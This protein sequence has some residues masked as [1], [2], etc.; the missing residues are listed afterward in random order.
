MKTDGDELLVNTIGSYTGTTAVGFRGE[1]A[2]AFIITAEGPW[3]VQVIPLEAIPR[4][5]LPVQGS[6]DDV[7]IVEDAPGAL[8]IACPGCTGNFAV[9]W[10]TANGA[11]LLVNDVGAYQGTVY[12]KDLGIAVV[13]ADGAWSIG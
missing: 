6:T 5:P 11:D 10:Y 9:W 3:T 13:T 7:F 12:A 1:K 8:P 4:K 2:T